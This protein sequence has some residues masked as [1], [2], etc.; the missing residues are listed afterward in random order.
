VVLPVVGVAA[1]T[2]AFRVELA[3]KVMLR[4][5]ISEARDTVISS[6]SFLEHAAVE[7]MAVVLSLKRRHNGAATWRLISS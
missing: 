2:E 1:G 4:I 3:G 7:A 6:S 5:S